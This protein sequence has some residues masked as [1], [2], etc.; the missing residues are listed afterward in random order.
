MQWSILR[1]WGY[2][3]NKKDNMNNMVL[4]QCLIL[5]PNL[6]HSFI[7]VVVFIKSV[8]QDGLT[9]EGLTIH[10]VRWMSHF[11][12]VWNRSLGLLRFHAVCVSRAH[13]TGVK[14]DRIYLCLK[15][16]CK[17]YVNVQHYACFAWWY[18]KHMIYSEKVIKNASKPKTILICCRES[19][20]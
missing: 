19:K 13:C 3:W 9:G 15:F 8:S 18:N 2:L 10:D 5:K 1:H 17:I 20:I 7:I 16:S 4:R 14:E 12:I 6:R 11:S